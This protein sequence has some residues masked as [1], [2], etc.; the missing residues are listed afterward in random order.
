[1]KDFLDRHNHRILGVING[2]DRMRFRGSLREM[3]YAM[4]MFRYL[5]NSQ[6][7]LTSQRLNV[8]PTNS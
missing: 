2:F 7:K 6:V 5:W 3:A 1:M 4:G 8:W